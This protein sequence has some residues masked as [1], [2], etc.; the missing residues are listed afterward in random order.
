MCAAG[1]V[2]ALAP[3]YQIAKETRAIRFIPGENPA[4][5]IHVDFTVRNSGTSELNFID[6]RLPSGQSTGRTD[7]RVEVD[8][9]ETV[10]SA[11]PRDES[12]SPPGLV[13]IALAKPWMRKQRLELRFD[14]TL[15]SPAYS[16]AYVTIDSNSFHLGVRG[17]AP[18]LQ[19]PEHLLA[20]YPS[21]PSRMT[22]AIRVP[23]NFAVLAGG[24][25]KG[26][27]RLGAEIEYRYELN[28]AALG[29]FAAAGRYASWPANTSRKAVTFWTTEPLRE[30]PAESAEQVA[31]IWS[32]LTKNFGVFDPSIAAPHLVESASV[33]DPFGRRSDPAAVGFPGGALL[34][35]PAFDLRIGSTRFFEIVGAALARNWFDIEVLPSAEAEVGM[36]D[37]LPEYA[38]VVADEARNGASARRQRIR[39]YLQLYDAAAKNADETPIAATTASSPAAQLRI[40]MAKA[41]LFY[42][43]LEDACGEAQVRAGLAHMLVSLRGQEVDYHVLRSALE[44]STGRDL[45]RT[46]R[47]WLDQKGVPGDFRAR[48]SLPA[49]V[50]GVRD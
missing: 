49:D 13:R 36:G 4:L 47:Q 26:Q 22:Y 1:C 11:L 31:L 30:N 7:L 6:V 35:P 27:K 46:F 33:Q 18:Q 19:P 21:R 24:L 17:W 20:A 25:A 45:G 38:S 28:S 3:G 15:R 16:A 50:Q 37:G 40:A 41:P 44:E 34:N 2:V 32:A 5:A 42:I 8:G 43:A 23:A 48:Y 10:P 12:P 39:R 9:A 29:A 14:Y